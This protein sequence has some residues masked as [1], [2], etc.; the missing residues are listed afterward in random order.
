MMQQ[1]VFGVMTQGAFFDARKLSA[2][3]KIFFFAAA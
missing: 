2:D 3:G 1:G